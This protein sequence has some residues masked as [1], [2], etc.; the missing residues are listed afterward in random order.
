[1]NIRQYLQADLTTAAAITALVTKVSAGDRTGP[2]LPCLVW[3]CIKAEDGEDVEGPDDDRMARFEIVIWAPTLEDCLAI[4]DV[5]KARYH[6]TEGYVIGG[7]EKLEIDSSRKIDEYDGDRIY[8][9]YST[10]GAVALT[11]VF[12]FMWTE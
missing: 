8:D 11:L 12:E 3:R 1:M 4:M 10:E 7:A 9:T 6:G 2:T 5:L